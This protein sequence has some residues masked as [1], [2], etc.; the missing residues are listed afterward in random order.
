MLTVVELVVFV[1]KFNYVVSD[2]LLKNLDDMRSEGNWSVICWK[3]LMSSFVDRYDVSLLELF[4]RDSLVKAF[5]PQ[6]SKRFRQRVFALLEE[7]CC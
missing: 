6:V 2:N 7:Y 5:P 1:Q 3:S 4:R